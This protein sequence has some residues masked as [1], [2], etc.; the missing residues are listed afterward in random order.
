MSLPKSFVERGLELAKGSKLFDTYFD[1][2]TRDELIAA[3]AHGWNEERK[4]RE[5]LAE[6]VEARAHW[7]VEQARKF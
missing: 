6:T 2:M 5:A 3:A 7:F 1:E 4:Q